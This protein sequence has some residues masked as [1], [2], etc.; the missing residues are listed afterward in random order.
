MMN[1]MWLAHC[2]LCCGSSSHQKTANFTFKRL[3]LVNRE[4]TGLTYSERGNKIACNNTW[5]GIA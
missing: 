3:P 2:E 4:C 1:R 5:Q